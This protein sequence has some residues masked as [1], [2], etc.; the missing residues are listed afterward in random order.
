MSGKRI[1]Y[2]SE[3]KAKVVLCALREEHSLSELTSRFGVNPTMISKWKK[4]AILGLSNIFSGKQEKGEES[5]DQA[6]KELHA[7]IGQLTVERDFLQEASSKLQFP[8]G[9]KW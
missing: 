3:F 6:I 9:K 8:G 4:Q 7:K 2:T 5:N 1:R